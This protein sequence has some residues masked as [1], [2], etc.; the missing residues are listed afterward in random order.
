MR[1]N[2][3]ITCK[4]IGPGEIGGYHNF[5]LGNQMFQIATALSYAFDNNKKVNM[6]KVKRLLVIDL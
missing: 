5:G 2:N 6:V 4:L 1:E 3:F